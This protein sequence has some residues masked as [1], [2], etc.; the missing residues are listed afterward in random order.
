MVLFSVKNSERD[1]R[2]LLNQTSTSC[3]LRKCNVYL[4]YQIRRENNTEKMQ[5][6]LDL[7]DP[8]RKQHR[9][10]AMSTGLTRSDEKTTPRK[11]KIYWT[12]QIRRENNTEKMQCLLDL[13]DPTR[14][15]HRENAMSTGLT[16]SDEKTTPRKCNVYWTYQIRRENNTEKMQCLL[17]LPDPTRKQH[18][19]VQKQP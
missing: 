6:L 16:R 5:C 3:T 14:K 17:D 12:Y 4:T 2:F 11:C 1:F 19:P 7:P 18:Q 10:N 9:E 15:Q 13:P 8:T